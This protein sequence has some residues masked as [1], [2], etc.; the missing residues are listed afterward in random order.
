MP[1]CSLCIGNQVR[2]AAKFT[3]V[4]TSTRN[5]PNCLG[6]GADVFLASAKLAAVAAIAGKLPTVTAYLEYSNTY[7]VMSG[8]IYRYLHFEKMDYYVQKASN[9][10]H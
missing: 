7:G 6:D 4:S 1:G 8:E 5:F 2:I 9:V 3:T 10:I